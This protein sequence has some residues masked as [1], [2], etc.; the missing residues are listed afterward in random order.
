MDIAAAGAAGVRRDLGGVIGAGDGDDYGLLATGETLQLTY[1]IRATDSDASH[2]TDDQT[3]VVTITGTNDAPLIAADTGVHGLTE[4]DTA[5]TTSGTLVVSDADVT[6]T[7]AASIYGISVSGSGNASRPAGL[8]D[9]MLQA[10]L[11]VDAG[12][13]IDNAHTDGTIH[14]S[15][16]SAPQAFDFLATDETL[17][18]TYTIRATDSDASHAC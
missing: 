18:L 10:M 8:T 1:T 7:V 6:N 14:W 2:A 4:G 16:N 5:L 12:N 17:Q 13:V 3:V 15:F 11:S 9:A